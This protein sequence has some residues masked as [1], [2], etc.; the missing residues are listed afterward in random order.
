MRAP[1]PEADRMWSLVDRYFLLEIVKVFSAI[2][3]TLLLV[4]ASMLFLRTLEQVN[5]GALQAGSVL[6]F[7]GLQLLRDTATLLAPAAFLAA[8]M[9]LGRMARDS[10]LIAFT[11]GGLGPGRTLRAVLLFTVPVALF[12][13]WLSLELK[14]WASAQIQLIEARQD[15]EAT[16]ISGLQSGRFYQQADGA[17]TFF[18]ADLDSDNRFA[19]VFVQDRRS[20]PPRV[21]LSERG[22]FLESASDGTQTV[23]LEDGRRFDGVAGSLDYTLLS[24]D[25]LTYFVTG[26]D[27]A[28]AAQLRRAATPTAVLLTS[29]NI[30]DHAEIQHRLAAAFGVIA[31]PLLAIPLTQLSPRRRG[32][33]RLFLAFLAYFAFFNGQQLAEEWMITGLTPPWLGMLWY[34]VVI[35]T[36]VFGSLLPGSY[37]SRRLLDQVFGYRRNHGLSAASGT[38]PRA[39]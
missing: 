17:M 24:F 2:L 39:R 30:R 11:A 25:K 33:G 21:L 8:L 20:N 37:W 36:V 22:Y 3:A 28:Q 14:P 35:V 16:R 32:S 38:A 26:A 13:A 31:L 10:E 5:L 7:L 9:A 27:P 23:V 6:R 4:V 15:D 18:A 19:G 29:D 34:Q 1:L 12:T